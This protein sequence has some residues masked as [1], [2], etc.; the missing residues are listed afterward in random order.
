LVELALV[1]AANAGVVTPMV[2]L[3]IV[4]LVM[5]TPSKLG[6]VGAKNGVPAGPIKLMHSYGGKGSKVPWTG[7]ILVVIVF[8]VE[9]DMVNPLFVS[10]ERQIERVCC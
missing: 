3:L 2:V 8:A 9:L 6:F 10:Y 1:N 5:L 7:T 4:L